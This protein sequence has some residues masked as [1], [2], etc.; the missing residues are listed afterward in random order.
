MARI[1]SVKPELR[2]SQLV[3]S[4]PFETRYFW[5]L[6]WGYLDDYGRGHDIPKLIAGDCFPRDERI[7]GKIID[8][9][10]DLMAAKHDHEPGPV[11]R[12]TV[13]GTAYLHA[14]NWREHQRPNR[15][16]PS[17]LPQCPIH[18]S[19]TEPLS[20]PGREYVSESLHVGAGEQG[21]RGAGEQQQALRES[22]GEP[23]P[24][25]AAVKIIL[26]TLEADGCSAAEARAIAERVRR[27]RRPRNLAGLLRTIAKAGE[28]GE[29][30]REVRA[31]DAKTEAKAAIAAAR[32]GPECPHGQPGGESLH[33]TTGRPLCAL[34]REGTPS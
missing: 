16:T 20:E 23:P 6:L 19:L 17:R 22:G 24:T 32:D 1:R 13:A 14:T 8:G 26:E 31:A 15:P 29:L 21:S 27:E 12:Y 33:P 30:L 25:A 34:C 4:W 28:L 3:A 11:C 18:E 5:V 10:L 9:W 2:T 7:T